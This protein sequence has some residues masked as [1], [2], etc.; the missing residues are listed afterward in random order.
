MTDEIDLFR[1]NPEAYYKKLE[2]YDLHLFGK[3]F[4]NSLDRYVSL[5]HIQEPSLEFSPPDYEGKEGLERLKIS[6]TFKDLFGEDKNLKYNIDVDKKYLSIGV[7]MIHSA[8]KGKGDF[9]V[10]ERE[11]IEKTVHMVGSFNRFLGTFL[12][13]Q[14]T[15]MGFGY[16]SLLDEIIPKRKT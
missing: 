15:K 10:V 13:V 14:A 1:A 3:S 6:I 11:G 2:D 7:V 4:S 5:S 12:N 8:F 16:H 9:R